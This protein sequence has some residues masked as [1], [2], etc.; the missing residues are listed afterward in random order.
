MAKT[1]YPILDF[2]KR[3]NKETIQNLADIAKIS[4]SACHKKILGQSDFSLEEAQKI[5]K[6]YK[7]ST[8]IL[9]SGNDEFLQEVIKKHNERSN[10]IG[11]ALWNGSGI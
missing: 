11:Y 3:Y 5:A 7:I 4:I 8:D 2:Y 6:H 9:F 10:E 1:K